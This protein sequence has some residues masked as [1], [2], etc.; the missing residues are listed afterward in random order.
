M[1]R[2]IYLG[3][4]NLQV[5]LEVTESESSKKSNEKVREG[6]ECSPEQ[7]MGFLSYPLSVCPAWFHNKTFSV[8]IV[9]LLKVKHIVCPALQIVV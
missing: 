6:Q 4:R 1:Q 7:I 9:E 2:K 5:L 3:V 8:H